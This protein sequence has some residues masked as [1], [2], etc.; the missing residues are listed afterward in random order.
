VIRIPESPRVRRRLTWGGIAAILV[1]AG[2][3]IALLV[4][5]KSPSNAEPTGS[6]VP[7]QLAV[8]THRKLSA[9]DRRAIDTLLDRFFP[10]AVER[11]NPN[12]AWSLAGPEMRQASSLS[13]FRKGKSPVPS[14]PANEANYHHWRAIDVEKGSVVLNILVHPKNPKTLGT[15]V[16]SVLA[17]KSNGRWLVDHLYPIAIM[18]PPVRPV[19]VTHELG[20]ADYAAPPPV[21]RTSATKSPSSHSYLLPVVAIFLV[22]LL[23]PLTLGAVALIR[24]RRWKRAVRASGRTELPPL[25]STYRPGS[26]E[27]NELASQ[28]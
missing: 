16:F 3:A 6:R 22:L 4:P 28:P 9:A 21:S 25:P 10:A 24:A 11:Q 13:D 19:T 27:Q 12:L 18:N 26:E 8:D 20:P 23:I 7:A 14:Y 5:G 15:W 1:A 17:V 2:V